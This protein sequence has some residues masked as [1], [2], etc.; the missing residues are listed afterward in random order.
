MSTERESAPS[1]SYPIWSGSVDD[2]V[3]CNSTH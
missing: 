3:G 2:P 1:D